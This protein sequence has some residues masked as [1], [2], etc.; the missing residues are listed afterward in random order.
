MVWFE[1]IR[2]SYGVIKNQKKI[3]LLPVASA[4]LIVGAGLVL[5]MNVILSMLYGNFIFQLTSI[6][7]LQVLVFYFVTY[8]ISI[9]FNAAIVDIAIQELKG[10][11]VSVSD[12]LSVAAKR[13]DRVLEWTTIAATV[14]IAV[15]LVSNNKIARIFA[16]IFE[17]GWEFASLFVI[18]IFV[19][20]DLSAWK[21]FKESLSL[22]KKT[23]GTSIVGG[24]SIGVLNFVLLLAGLV[25]AMGVIVVSPQI[26]VIF[27]TIVV[28]IIY[29]AV[30][31]SFFSVLQQVFVAAL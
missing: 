13:L 2:E 7:Y 21:A 19:Y 27:A 9:F 31:I 14:G 17:L 8:F 22:F 29:A 18:P 15:R 12:G 23:W 16:N 25:V 20:Q 24:L 28:Y 11:K 26:S 10:K 30:V 5:F 6:F 1:L 4:L 3:L